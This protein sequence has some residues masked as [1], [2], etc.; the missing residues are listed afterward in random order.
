MRSTE[1]KV[2]PQSDY[3]IYTPS[4]LARKLYLY[5]LLAGYFIYEPGYFIK[6][7]HFDNFLIMYISKGICTVSAGSKSYTASAGQ[8]V[9]LDCYHPHSYGSEDLWE[10]VWMHFDGP[11]A[12]A[13]YDEIWS[14]CG[15]VIS[16]AHPEVLSG[17]LSRI[18]EIFRT[19]CP[20]AENTLSDYITR[21]LNGLL[22]SVQGKKR[23][24]LRTS[25]ITDTIAYINEHFHESLSLD[26]LAKQANISP[27][28]FTRIFA[29]ETGMTPHH[30]LIATRISAAKF[31]LKSSGTSIKEIAFRTG[32]Q[33]ETSFC[34]T[35]KKWEGCTPSQYRTSGTLPPSKTG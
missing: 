24:A 7:N 1:F 29:K 2:S 18:Y 32:F 14:G 12:R 13:Y 16:P 8:F 26:A 33:S 34:N 5:P 11:L 28:H 17:L 21:I 35:F 9:L 27:Y 23:S 20:L 25:S 22:F 3:Y 6:R 15:P 30:Y 4:A 31:L 10:A 19:S